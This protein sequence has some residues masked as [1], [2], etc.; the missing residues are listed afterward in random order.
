MGFIRV[1]HKNKWVAFAMQSAFS[2]LTIVVILMTDDY[3]K[4]HIASSRMRNWHKYVVHL[5]SSFISVYL[6]IIV[7]E[8]LFGYGEVLVPASYNKK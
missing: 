7:L 4:A 1:N 3:L 5:F 2:A 8:I 6:V